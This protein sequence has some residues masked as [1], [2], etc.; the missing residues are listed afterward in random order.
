M[1]KR[2]IQEEVKSLALDRHKMAFISGPRQCGKTT[3]SKMF[4]SDQSLYFNWDQLKFR[5]QWIK[6]PSELAEKALK[7]KNPR[8]AIDEIHKNRR[9]KTQLKGF[10]DEYG[11]KIEIVV[12]GSAR[13]NVYR[14]GGDSLLGRF[15]HFHLLP[16]SLSEFTQTK[17]ANF[18]DFSE[19][20][21][22][23][24][25]SSGRKGREE[26]QALLKF[27]G[28]PEPLLSGREDILQL[29]QRNRIDL[30]IQQDLRDL[31]RIVELSQVEVLASLL[32]MKVGSPLSVQSLREDLE[33]AFTTV[34]RW[35]HFLEALYFHF[36]VRPYSK[37]IV[38]SLKK[39]PKLYLYDWS[40]I[41]DTGARFE[42][43][44]AIHLLK[45]CQHWSDLGKSDLELF[46]LRNKEK[47][48]IDFIIQKN[49]KPWFTVEAKLNQVHL[50]P[51]YQ[52]FQKQLNVPHFQI[53][54]E[55][56]ISRVFKT[57]TGIARVLSFDR[58]FSQTP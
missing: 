28:F 8:I 2:Q 6:N 35:L 50:D 31:S 33:V 52:V 26:V 41:E 1:Y 14:K 22:S 47:N 43:M 48:E 40:S 54:A 56:G 3:L 39:E 20:I 21:S 38:R 13:F 58:F 17:I 10:Y 7:H 16:F 44:V 34:K 30:L 5:Q 36:E 46:Y 37:S 4:L 19:F 57:D 51:K 25:I 29:W 49:K 45:L 9:W 12:T 55:P 32:P 42:N 11:D 27:G 53:V 24:E 23:S 18:R 15:L